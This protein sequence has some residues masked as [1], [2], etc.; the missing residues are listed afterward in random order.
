M[1]AQRPN[2]DAFVKS[3]KFPAGGDPS[4]PT[5]PGAVGRTARRGSGGR[6]LAHPPADAGRAA[7]KLS[8]WA[9][10]AGWKQDEKPSQPRELSFD[11]RPGRQ[12]GREGGGER[13]PACPGRQRRRTPAGH[14]HVAR[15]GRAWSRCRPDQ[16]NGRGDEAGNKSG[17]GPAALFEFA[18]PQAD[19]PEK[20]V[21]VAMVLRGGDLWFFKIAGPA[22][23][24]EAQKPTFIGFV[25]SAEFA[26]K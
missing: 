21:V 2:F 6:R 18:G 11:G 25:N 23:V 14:Q 5:A 10:P 17:A 20:R 13:V 26:A 24:V 12:A 19:K 4:A 22:A 1:E 9:T 7:Q 16:F 3:V 15:P 8:K